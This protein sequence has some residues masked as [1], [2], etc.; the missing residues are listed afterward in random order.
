MLTWE[1]WLES[2]SCGVHGNFIQLSYTREIGWW[3]ILLLLNLK[4]LKLKWFESLFYELKSKRLFALELMEIISGLIFKLIMSTKH[5]F[6]LLFNIWSWFLQ[7]SPL[8]LCNDHS[9]ILIFILC[10]HIFKA[11][12][13]ILHL[14]FTEDFIDRSHSLS[15]L[16]LI[17][18]FLWEL[19]LS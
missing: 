3:H 19:P 13:L 12:W 11:I 6:V 1:E 5:R 7:K 14:L 17:I 16:L 9:I 4:V 10:F 18:A 8:F 15:I 2:T